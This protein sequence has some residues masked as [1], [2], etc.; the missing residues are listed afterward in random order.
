MKKL[1]V[2]FYLFVFL[3]NASSVNANWFIFTQRYSADPCVIV[4][5]GRVY[6]YMSHDLDNSN[7]FLM[8][9]YTCISSDDLINWTDHGEVAL[10]ANIPYINST[11][12]PKHFWAP[13]AVY[14]NGKFYLYFCIP[15]YTDADASTTGTG[16]LVSD[17]PTGPFTDPRGSLLR[18]GQSVDCSVMIDG[19]GQ[20]YIY[21]PNGPTRKLSPNM[22][23]YAD[24]NE[25]N[26]WNNDVGE[27]PYVFRA[28]NKYYYSYMTFNDQELWSCAQ[29][30]SGCNDGD[31]N[32]F[33]RYNFLAGPT[34]GVIE[35]GGVHG[36]TM[37]W[38]TNG[39]NTQPAVFQFNNNWYSLYHSKTLVKIRGGDLG[40]QRNVGLDR[41][42]F[43]PD[44]TIIPQ[45]I[46]KPKQWLANG[47]LKQNPL[48]MLVEAEM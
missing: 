43:N 31:A 40:Y 15:S 37:M 26:V 44:G 12:N 23:E 22:Y 6:V 20:A 29:H 34:G 46:T 36:R 25:S 39:D 2:F 32:Y 38:P 9:G 30:N 5:G 10:A 18:T 41:I 28:N 19:D 17:S 35:P 4:Y 42:Y 11:G 48:V 47:E 24:G 27:A 1:L 33:H 21:W 16:V 8:D 45:T 14:R 13:E 7:G 3:L